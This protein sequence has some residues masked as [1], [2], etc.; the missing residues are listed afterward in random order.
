MP[1]KIR[2][3]QGAA[4]ANSHADDGTRNITHASTRNDS[5]LVIL[6]D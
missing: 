2:G 5:S 6:N 3:C 1:Q 4:V